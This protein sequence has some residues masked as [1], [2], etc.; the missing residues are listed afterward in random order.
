M[1]TSPCGQVAGDLGVAV[2]GSS[3]L[4][5]V[6]PSRPVVGG[7]ADE[8]ALAAMEVVPGDIHASIEGAALV[9]VRPAGPVVVKTAGDVNAVMSPASRGG[10]PGS[11]GLVA[12]QAQSAAALIEKGDVPSAG[13]T[14][15]QNKG[16]ALI[17]GEGALTIGKGKAGEGVAAVGGDRCAGGVDGDGVAAS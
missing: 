11:G 9:V 14:V 4:S 1:Y 13:R 8:D 17:I 6:R 3:D 5:L 12:A 10:V 16:L 2:E 7:V 15:K